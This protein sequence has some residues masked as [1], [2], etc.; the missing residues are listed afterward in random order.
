[1]YETCTGGEVNR[2]SMCFKYLASAFSCS[3]RNPSLRFPLHNLFAYNCSDKHYETHVFAAGYMCITNRKR[4]SCTQEKNSMS[5][6]HLDEVQSTSFKLSKQKES[7][8]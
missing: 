5:G 2:I 7:E 3:W 6:P 4:E 1:M 8:I